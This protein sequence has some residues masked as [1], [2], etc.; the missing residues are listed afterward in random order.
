MRGGGYAYYAGKMFVRRAMADLNGT[1]IVLGY[2]GRKASRKDPYL[3]FKEQVAPDGHTPHVS[4]SRNA[5]HREKKM[6]EYRYYMM[7]YNSEQNA[8]TEN[9]I[10]SAVVGSEKGGGSFKLCLASAMSSS[11]Y[12]N[13]PAELCCSHQR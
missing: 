9:I 6:Q 11:Q 13:T 1:T 7:D 2:E 10:S 5:I 8:A 4:E 3:F 12:T